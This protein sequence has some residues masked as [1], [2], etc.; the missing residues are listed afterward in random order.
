M[1]QP[2]IWC[3]KVTSTT[4]LVSTAAKSIS[5]A[6][7]RASLKVKPTGFCMKEFAARMK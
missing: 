7:P 2:A 1:K 3:G 4:G 5:S 6:R